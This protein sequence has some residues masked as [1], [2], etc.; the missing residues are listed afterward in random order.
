MGSAERILSLSGTALDIDPE[1][2]LADTLEAV[3]VTPASEAATLT[4]WAWAER[5][6]RLSD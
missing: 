2:Y 1:A 5:N 3:A 6:A 4:P